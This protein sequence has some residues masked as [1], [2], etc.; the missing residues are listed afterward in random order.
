[1]KYLVKHD[2]GKKLDDQLHTKF[3]NHLYN[4][5]DLYVESYFIIYLILSMQRSLTS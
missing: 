2:N 1:M 5:L 4:Q 3:S